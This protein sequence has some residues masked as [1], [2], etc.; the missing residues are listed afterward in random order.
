MAHFEVTLDGQAAELS[1]SGVVDAR[2]AEELIQLLD[3]VEAEEVVLDFTH[4]QLLQDVLFGALAEALETRD[5][6]HLRG[7]REHHL[8]LLQYLKLQLDEAGTLRP[9]EGGEHAPL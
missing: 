2:A 4:V 8:R 6:L 7:L 3:E 9:L 1:I 5:R